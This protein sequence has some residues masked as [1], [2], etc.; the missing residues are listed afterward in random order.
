MITF[1]RLSFYDIVN[2]MTYNV[3]WFKKDLR[4]RDHE[5][6]SSA[7]RDWRTIGLFI[8][9]PEWLTSPEF[10]PSHYVF[11]EQ[12][13]QELKKE[14]SSIGVPLIVEVGE[15]RD[16]LQK[17]HFQYK[18]RTLFSHEETGLNW[19]FQ[20]DLRVKRWTKSENIPWKESRQFGV[21]RGLKSRDVWAK[22]RNQTVHRKLVKLESQSQSVLNE[23]QSSPI[24]TISDLGLSPS[25]IKNAQIGGRQQGERTLESFMSSRGLQYM[26]SLSSPANSQAGCSRLSPFLTWGN[27]SVSEVLHAIDNKRATLRDTPQDRNWLK[28]L[29]HFESRLAWHCHFIQKLESE[30]EIEFQNMNRAFDGLRENDF[31]EDYF[32]AWCKGETGFP[33]IDAGMRALKMNGWINFRMRATLM[34]F[35]SYQLWLHWRRPAQFLAKHFIDFEPGIHFSQ[36]QM[37]SGVTGINTIRIYSPKKQAAEKDPNGIFIRRYCPELSKLSNVDLAEPH[38]VP[39][40]LAQSI[41]FTLG[42]DYPEP[43]VDPESAYHNAKKRI[44]E[45]MEKPPV[46]SAARHVYQRHGSRSNSGST[47]R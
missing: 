44:F 34:S 1:A 3:V 27:L 38:L 6:L 18:I 23:I 39:P 22:L 46:R 10:D 32:E 21:I 47:K 8:I 26:S 30:P 5:P 25:G 41:G 12:S 45:W 43:I 17:L 11:M 13:L 9:E 19:T 35:A 16:V 29:E 14:L 28:N 15:T 37:Q 31:N 24:P 7:I 40:L 36:A 4:T 20:R 42:R 2:D 33:I